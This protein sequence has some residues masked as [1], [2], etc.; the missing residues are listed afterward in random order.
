[1]KMTYLYE[2]IRNY[3]KIFTIK[4]TIATEFIPLDTDPPS[5]PKAAAAIIKFY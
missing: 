1:M 2:R 3:N 4:F 5:A